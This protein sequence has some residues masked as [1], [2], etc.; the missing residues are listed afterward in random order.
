VAHAFWKRP[1]FRAVVLYP[2]GRVSPRQERQ[3]AC[4]GENVHALA[5]DGSFDDCQALAKACFADGALSGEL[6][7]T[8]A[9]SI[10]IARLLA[11]ALYYFEAVAQ[12]R[13]RGTSEA[14]VI[15][16][17]SG[18]FGNLCAGLMA[19]EMGLPVKAFVAATNANDTVP[20]FLAGGT[21]RPRP[22]VP[23]L[24]NAM[25]VGAP[26]NWE[27]IAAFA[28]DPATL[29]QSLRWDR[30]TDTETLKAM[31]E[32][33]RLDAEAC[34]HSALAWGVLKRRLQPG[35]TGIFLATAH[36]AKF[37]DVVRQATGREPALPPALAELEHAQVRSLPQ[38]NDAR[39]LKARLRSLCRG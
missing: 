26:S 36:A 15:A 27:R 5:V 21:Y 25:D 12:V 7:L 2:T 16:V 17:P 35:E 14:P 29:R 3:F 24:S 11:Q 19:Q 30:F 8:S 34:P 39:S 20:E 9:N 22:S 18:N 28:G 6:G 31:Q 32:L 10:N 33:Q 4:L 1:G 37:P 38:A 13:A 23:T